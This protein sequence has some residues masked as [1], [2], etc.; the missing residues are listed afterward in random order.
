MVGISTWMHSPGIQAENHWLSHGVGCMTHDVVR[1]LPIFVVTAWMVFRALPLRA[2][3]AGLLGGAGDT[4]TGPG[5]Y[6]I[7][8]YANNGEEDFDYAQAL[9]RHAQAALEVARLHRVALEKERQDRELQIAQEIQRSLFPRSRPT[10]SGLELAAESRPCHQVG[11]DYYD[12]VPLP[13]PGGGGPT[14]SGSF[15][16]RRGISP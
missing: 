3:V 11:G 15:A 7:G 6:V 5:R 9:G 1:V 8:L 16:I 14:Y 2:P 13:G 12:Y 10:V 4:G